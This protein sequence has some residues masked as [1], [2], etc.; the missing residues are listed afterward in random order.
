MG[1]RFSRSSIGVDKAIR[2]C[3]EVLWLVQCMFY[4]TL[5]TQQIESSYICQI[6]KFLTTDLQALNFILTAPEFEKSYEG[7]QFLEEVVGRGWP[8]FLDVVGI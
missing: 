2:S 1:A 5:S 6:A 7:R 3:N 8:K 4:F